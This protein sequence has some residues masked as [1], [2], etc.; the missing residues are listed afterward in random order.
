MSDMA[1]Y[2]ID[3]Y[4]DGLDPASECNP[5]VLY[6]PRPYSCFWRGLM[7]WEELVAHR[8]KVA[9][10]R[11]AVMERMNEHVE[12]LMAEWSGEHHD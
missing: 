5:E 8:A 10:I 1:Q 9:A 11:A 3:D 7:T 2:R 4:L 12:R 6:D